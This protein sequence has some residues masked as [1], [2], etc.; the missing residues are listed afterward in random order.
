MN[1]PWIDASFIEKFSFKLLP[2]SFLLLHFQLQNFY[3]FSSKLYNNNNVKQ[4]WNFILASNERE[5]ESWLN[6]KTMVAMLIIDFN[7]E[8]S[9]II[10]GPLA[11]HEKFYGSCIKT[12]FYST[13]RVVKVNWN[14][15]EIKKKE[16][17][18]L[19]CLFFFWDESYRNNNIKLSTSYRSVGCMIL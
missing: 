9:R 1:I 16:F 7:S 11:S 3:F 19:F 12:G 5:M 15:C 6:W 10:K 18:V 14:C 8:W 2:Q 4:Q 13:R 17:G